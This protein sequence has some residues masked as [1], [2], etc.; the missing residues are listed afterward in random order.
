MFSKFPGL[1]VFV[2]GDRVKIFIRVAYTWE[3]LFLEV[4]CRRGGG[5]EGR[6]RD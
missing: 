1:G 3:L 4:V 2:G 6:V 5:F